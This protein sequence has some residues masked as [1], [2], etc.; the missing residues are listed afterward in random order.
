MPQPTA[1]L[2]SIIV[3]IKISNFFISRFSHQNGIVAG[4]AGLSI[5]RRMP[6]LARKARE[7]MAPS[8]PSGCLHRDRKHLRSS[9]KDFRTLQAGLVDKPACET[10]RISGTQQRYSAKTPRSSKSVTSSLFDSPIETVSFPA[11]LSPWK[12]YTML[13]DVQTQHGCF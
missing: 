2:S 5:R 8:S 12:L 11:K 9:R 6:L 13:N 10:I 4:K 1:L 3:I 7:F